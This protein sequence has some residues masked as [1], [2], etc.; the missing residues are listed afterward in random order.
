MAEESAKKN[1]KVHKLFGT[2]LS[3][4]IAP[5]KYPKYFYWIT[6]VLIVQ[7]LR[8]LPIIKTTLIQHVVPAGVYLD[9]IL[10]PREM[11]YFNFSESFHPSKHKTSV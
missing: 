8:R 10:Q 5:L 2:N 3:G 4:R 9:Q 6:V 7:R 11:L 1:F